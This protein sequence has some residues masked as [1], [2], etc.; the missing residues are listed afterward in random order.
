M[1]PAKLLDAEVQ[2]GVEVAHE[3]KRDMHFALDSLQLAEQQAECHAVAQGARGCVLYHRA[4]GHRVAKGDAH[5]D[6]VDAA[7]LHGPYDLGRAVK[8]GAAGTEVE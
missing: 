7:A 5:L 3:D 8:G 4:V 1:A 6:E 2:D